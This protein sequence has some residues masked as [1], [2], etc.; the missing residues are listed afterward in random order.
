MKQTNVV[1]IALSLPIM[2]GGQCNTGLLPDT[3]LSIEQI[4]N[5]PSGDAQGTVNWGTYRPV[6]NVRTSCD[7]CAL[8]T[9][10]ESTCTDS[11][12]DPNARA[13][14]VQV[15]GAL[16]A[17][18]TDGLELS[19]GVNVD[20]TFTLGS[21]IT[22]MFDDG[23]SGGQGLGLFEGQFV[24]ERIIGTLTSRLTVNDTDGRTIDLL[25][26]ATVVYER[27]NE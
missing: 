1:V 2:L 25:A 16:S 23:S 12:V 4:I 19:G 9:V 17:T 3:C 20:G 8:N 15:D 14:F 26:V 13:T 21:I 27:V 10:P 6:S 7:Q 18:G 5:I 11:T 24:G 22:P